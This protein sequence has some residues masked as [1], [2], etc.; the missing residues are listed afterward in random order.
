MMGRGRVARSIRAVPQAP[1]FASSG[2]ERLGQ[3]VAP[4]QAKDP[5]P[6]GSG[7]DAVADRHEEG[8]D[9]SAGANHLTDDLPGIEQPS[10]AAAPSTGH[11]AS[12]REQ[13]VGAADGR[14]IEPQ[15]EMAGQAQAPGVGAP[16]TGAEDQVGPRMQAIDGRQ[17][18]G[19]LTE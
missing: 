14:K 4:G 1:D 9:V 19:K 18:S 8:P 15:A 13:A 16:V 17:Q 10:V 11:A 3:P 6:G 2:A 7:A 12:A 5:L